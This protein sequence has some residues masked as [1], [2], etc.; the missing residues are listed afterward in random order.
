[1]TTATQYDLAEKFL[2]S[3]DRQELELTAEMMGVT[4][5]TYRETLT[6]CKKNKARLIADLLEYERQVLAKR[7]D[8]PLFCLA[9]DYLDYYDKDSIQWLQT[10]AR[11]RGISLTYKGFANRTVKKTDTQIKNEL[12]YETD[13]A[14]CF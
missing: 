6:N 3:L 13:Y 1:M 12:L 4:V 8:N 9:S 10:L 14:S 11:H 7:Y 2:D 5:T